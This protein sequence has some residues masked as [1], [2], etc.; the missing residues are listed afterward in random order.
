LGPSLTDRSAFAD[1]YR[2]YSLSELDYG[3]F[4][5]LAGQRVD[6]ET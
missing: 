1:A 4:N 6:W 5:F 2:D 3:L